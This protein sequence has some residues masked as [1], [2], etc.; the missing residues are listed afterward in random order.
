MTVVYFIQCHSS[1]AKLKF[2]LSSIYNEEDFFIIHCDKKS[3]DEIIAFSRHLS[4]Q[5]ENIYFQDPIYV[6]WGGYSQVEI[7][8]SALAKATQLADFW[9]H[10][11]LLSE[12]HIPTQ[13]RKEFLAGLGSG[14]SYVESRRFSSMPADARADIKHRLECEHREL[15]G[16]GMYP[17]RLVNR[18]HWIEENIYQGSNWVIL[19]RGDVFLLLEASIKNRDIVENLQESIQSDEI[20]VQSLLARTGNSSFENRCLTFVAWPHLSGTNDL[21][22]SEKNYATAVKDGY[23]FIRKS[24]DELPEAVKNHVEQNIK[25]GSHVLDAAMH[26][27]TYADRGY[28]SFRSPLADELMKSLHS[29]GLTFSDLSGTG[30]SNTPQFYQNLQLYPDVKITIISRDMLEYKISLIWDSYSNDLS[31]QK[32]GNFEA[33]VLKVRVAYLDYK[34]EIIADEKTGGFMSVRDKSEL[35][36]AIDY[37]VCLKDLAEQFKRLL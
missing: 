7:L 30:L 19:S 5:C 20:F 31:F 32:V 9:S 16:W 22:F 11:V 13:T 35:N 3:P 33:P 25:C 29:N 4:E 34:R 28:R 2:L 14:Q 26:G 10:F 17:V 24:P 12:H 18:H 23:S 27:F 15:A 37:I 21:T 36:S 8:L 1:T 6:S